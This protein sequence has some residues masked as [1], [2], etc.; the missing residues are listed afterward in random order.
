MAGRVLHICIVKCSVLEQH[1]ATVHVNVGLG[2]D[3][4]HKAAPH[5]W[6]DCFNKRHKAVVHIYG[7]TVQNNI[8][9]LFTYGLTVVINNIKL[10]FTYV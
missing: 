2:Y 4:Q 7:Q 10:R 6:A 5:I 8:K 1:E 3:K 9:L